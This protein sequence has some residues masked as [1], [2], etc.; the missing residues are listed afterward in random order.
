M[1][2]VLLKAPEVLLS[3]GKILL[4]LALAFIAGV[5]LLRLLVGSSP[6]GPMRPEDRD[7]HYMNASFSEVGGAFAAWQRMAPAPG[8]GA[9]VSD[10]SPRE[11]AGLIT[12]ATTR[13]DFFDDARLCDRSFPL[14][15]YTQHKN[16]AL[17]V[18]MKKVDGSFHA[19]LFSG[20][21]VTL[22]DAE[23]ER[24]TARGLVP[25]TPRKQRGHQP[26]FRRH[27]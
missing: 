5:I 16:D 4:A 10:Y 11:L 13:P 17:A 7:R 15:Q 3:A 25:I 14:D 22:T 18:Y 24:I 2:R 1:F 26:G 19:V 21:V 9:P 6:L 12:E 27:P 23:F 20:K 8:D